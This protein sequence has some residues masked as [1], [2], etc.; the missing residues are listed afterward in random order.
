MKHSAVNPNP[1]NCTLPG[2]FFRLFCRAKLKEMSLICLLAGMCTFHA[3][4]QNIIYVNAANTSGSQDGTSWATA[5]SNLQQGLRAALNAVGPDE[6]WVAAGTYTPDTCVSGCTDSIVRG[7]TFLLR[8]ETALLG[9]F[10]GTE[11]Q[12]TQRNPWTNPTILSGD[13]M[14]NDNPAEL[15][16]DAPSRSDN[17]NHVVTGDLADSSAVLDGFIVTGGNARTDILNTQ[18]GG[19]MINNAGSPTIRNCIFEY[20][21]AT[22]AGAMD[23]SNG[24]SPVVANCIFRHN[25]ASDLGGAISVFQT[26]TPYFINCLFYD[27]SAGET[28][29]AS[30]SGDNG[31]GATTIVHFYNCTF[32]NNSSVDLGPA[33]AGQLNS[34]AKFMNCILWDNKRAGAFS[35]QIKLSDSATVEVTYSIVQVQDTVPFSG[36]GNLM[37]DPDFFDAPNQDFRI[38]ASSPAV[39]AGGSVPLD[40]ADLDEDSLRSEPLPFDLAGNMR[41]QMVDGGGIDIGAYESD[42]VLDGLFGHRPANGLS[43]SL[44]PNPVSDGRLE[45]Q[46][47]GIIGPEVEISVWSLNGQQL[48]RTHGRASQGELYQQLQLPAMSKGLYLLRVSTPAQQAV[49]KFVRR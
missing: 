22:A 9:G 23:C 36:T 8:N 17:V 47:S 48:M 15:T 43:L 14:G 24:G 38:N 41:V 10:T 46:V 11:T 31:T 33:H 25:V 1:L 37:D 39:D 21:T 34:T 35:P 28:G 12:K 18:S 49:Q 27:N 44:L 20:N 7:A 16:K 13:L 42:G 19:G 29:G 30:Y 5:F 32:V 40:L 2:F 6:V 3:S 26:G 4:A 45:V